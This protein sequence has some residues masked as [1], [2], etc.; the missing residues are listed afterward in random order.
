MAYRPSATAC[1]LS[2]R[3]AGP[4]ATLGH[5][6]HRLAATRSPDRRKPIPASLSNLPSPN[7]PQRW[8]VGANGANDRRDDTRSALQAVR[9]M[10]AQ[11]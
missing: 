7:R 5:G 11:R 1:A 4:D 3:D 6:K 9:N 8:L 2:W 10:E